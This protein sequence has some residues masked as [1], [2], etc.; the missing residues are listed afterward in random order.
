VLSEC[1]RH[2]TVPVHLFQRKSCSFLSGILKDLTK[3][4][5]FSGGAAL[6]YKKRK[7]IINL[8][9]HKGDSDMDAK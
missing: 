3:N 9:Y 4:Y 1:L 7:Y 5:S 8:C 2:N 6:W